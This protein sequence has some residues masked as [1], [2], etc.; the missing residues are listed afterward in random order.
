MMFAMQVDL[1][2]KKKKLRIK[3]L[4]AYNKSSLSHLK[5]NRWDAKMLTK[6]KKKR[7]K[8][9]HQSGLMFYRHRVARKF[10]VSLRV[11]SMMPPQRRNEC[12]KGRSPL[13]H[14]H[15]KRCS[16]SSRGAHWLES[17]D[18][19]AGQREF[20]AEQQW[21]LKSRH[22]HRMM[23]SWKPGCPRGCAMS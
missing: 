14:K 16:S 1:Q 19:E 20:R 2:K 17:Q 18:P 12:S 3:N 23:P 13:A 15:F 9:N 6:K 21:V 11:S 10:H 5:E 7:E 22:A 4:C 8:K